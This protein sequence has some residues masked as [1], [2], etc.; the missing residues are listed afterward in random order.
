MDFSNCFGIYCFVE[1]YVCDEFSE[2]VRQ[3]VIQYFI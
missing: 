3:Y 2:K 1:V